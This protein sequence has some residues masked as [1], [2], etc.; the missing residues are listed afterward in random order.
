MTLF[1]GDP[2][3]ETRS[4]TVCGTRTRY[5]PTNPAS[6]NR[7][8]AA[9][10]SA[11]LRA[12]EYS[13]RNR[14]VNTIAGPI[15]FC[16]KKN[17][18]ERE[19]W[20]SVFERRNAAQA[21]ETRQPRALL[22][23]VPQDV[24]TLREVAGQKQDQQNADQLDGL[25]S[26]QVDFGVARAGTVP[27]HDQQRRKREAGQERHEAQLAQQTLVVERAGD[28]QEDASG[29]YALREI[30]EEQAIAHRIAQADH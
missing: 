15:S 19:C 14:Q 10:I 1:Q 17:I 9:A 20:N 27:E 24:P 18:N 25:K 11:S 21:V 12:I 8:P 29:G 7:R 16:K 22:A 28:G 23:D 5:P 3:M 4:Y 6:R 13:A 30:H 2:H 26:E